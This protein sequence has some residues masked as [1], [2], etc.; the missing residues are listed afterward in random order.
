MAPDSTVD[1]LVRFADDDGLLRNVAA[2]FV[3]IYIIAK[4]ILDSAESG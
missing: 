2:H 1:K 3:R 4:N